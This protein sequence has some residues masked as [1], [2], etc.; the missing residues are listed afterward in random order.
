MPP[1][2]FIDN[3]NSF[4]AVVLPPI[5]AFIHHSMPA[6]IFVFNLTK[7]PVGFSVANGESVIEH[8]RFLS[9]YRFILHQKWN[10]VHQ[11]VEEAVGFEPTVPFGTLVF[12]TRS[13][14]LSDTLPNGDPGRIR[15]PNLTVM[16]YRSACEFKNLLTCVWLQFHFFARRLIFPRSIRSSVTSHILCRMVALSNL[17]CPPPIL[18][19]I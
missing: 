13:I 1:L 4:F 3:L 18:P 6:M 8:L 14:D 16:S 11:K 12:K 9:D 10:N 15:T 17:L 19:L 2:P 5:E 7:N